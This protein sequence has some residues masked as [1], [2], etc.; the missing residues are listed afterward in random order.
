[1]ADEDRAVIVLEEMRARRERHLAVSD[2]GRVVRRADER[3]IDRK[4]HDRDPDPQDQVRQQVPEAALLDHQAHISRSFS[5]VASPCAQ[6]ASSFSPLFALAR[7]ASPI[8]PLGVM[9]LN[10]WKR[11]AGNALRGSPL[12]MPKASG[13]RS[14]F[15]VAGAT[16]I[17][18]EVS[19]SQA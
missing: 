7:R 15:T 10:E 4:R 1:S 8:T 9:S 13:R 2:G 11:E 17:I 18:I 5:A 6:T 16:T 3:E 14:C 19:T 12:S